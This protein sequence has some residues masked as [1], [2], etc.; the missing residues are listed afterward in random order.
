MRAKAE[1]NV[2]ETAFPAIVLERPDS[3]VDPMPRLGHAFPRTGHVG[4]FLR[5]EA[6]KA[7]FMAHA[8]GRK[9]RED[10]RAARDEAIRAHGDA[11]VAGPA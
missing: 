2:K 6:S 5:P 11:A 1:P 9:T 3:M 7:A 10:L 8:K 4:S